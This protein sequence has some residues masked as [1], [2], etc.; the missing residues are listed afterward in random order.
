MHYYMDICG[1]FFFLLFGENG[2]IFS[3]VSDLTLLAE[4]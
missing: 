4:F 2:H 3:F 1:F